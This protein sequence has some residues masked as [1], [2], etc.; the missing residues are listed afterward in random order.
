ME[1]D[2]HIWEPAKQFMKEDIRQLDEN[3]TVNIV[4]FHQSTAA[5]IRFKA[6]DFD[7]NAIESTCD[8]MFKES[9]RTGI[10]N[11]WDLGLK[12]IDRNR[13]NYLYLFTDGIENVHSQRTDAVCQRIKNWCKQA[14]NNYAFFVAL[15]KDMKNKPEVKKLIDATKSCDRTFFIDNKHPAPFGAFDKTNF[16]INCHSLRELSTGFSDYGTFDAAIECQDEYYTVKLKD[17]KIK[18]GKATFILVQ[19][20][21]PSINHQIR[22]NVKANLEDLNIC[23]PDF[24]VNIDTRDLANLDMGQ[25]SGATGQFDAGKADTYPSFLLWEGKMSDILEADLSAVFNEQAKKRNCSLKVSLDLPAEIKGRCIVYY[26][27]EKVGNSCVIN[28]TDKESIVSIEV[29]HDLAEKE[30]TIGMKGHPIGLETINAEECKMYE[31]SIYFEHEISW[32]P[33]Q[34]FFLWIS[35]LALV[36]LIL[37]FTILKPFMYPRIRLSRMELSSKKGYY[38]NKKINGTRRVVV[39]NKR[40][41]QS[42]LNKLFTGEILYIVNEIWTSPWELSPKGRSK[43]A[44]INLHGKYMITPVTSELVNYGEYQLAN[45]ETKESITIKIL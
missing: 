8:R 35:I 18:D 28:S 2:N 12:Y 17:G 16:N 20:R 32:N 39:S 45:I 26:N 5:P 36:L 9:K 25:P 1:R 31:S 10:C 14:P 42:F 29:P 7:W 33:L 40:N 4:L 21:Q 15:G 24:Y 41:K 34:T 6:K 13:N 44:K 27:G 30:F 38:V 22:F 43:V 19:S 37:W 3:A 11:A 23:N